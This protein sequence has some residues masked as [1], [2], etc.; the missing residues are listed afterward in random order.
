MT[1]WKLNQSRRVPL[2]TTGFLETKSGLLVRVSII[3]RVFL[4]FSGSPTHLAKLDLVAS[5]SDLV[6]IFI[7]LIHCSSWSSPSFSG[8]PLSLPSNLI[9]LM[10]SGL[11]TQF[12]SS[13]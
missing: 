7:A 8:V 9:L 4:R 2:V 10:N 5:Q 13:L 12:L 11:L 1:G 6:T 3:L